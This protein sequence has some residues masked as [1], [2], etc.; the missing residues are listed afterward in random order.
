MPSCPFVFLSPL[1]N[2]VP[3]SLKTPLPQG[4]VPAADGK[5]RSKD[6]PYVT[7]HRSPLLLVGGGGGS[8]V[9]PC[10]H[11]CIYNTGYLK[12]PFSYIRNTGALQKYKQ[13]EEDYTLWAECLGGYVTPNPHVEVLSVFNMC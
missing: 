10:Q 2:Q 5:A 13:R 4:D 12:M 1:S 8:E 6:S 7:G 11:L 3:S 9:L